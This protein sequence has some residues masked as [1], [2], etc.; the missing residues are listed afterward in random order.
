MNSFGIKR[1]KGHVRRVP[2]TMNKLEAAWATELDSQKNQGVIL[3]YWFEG[4]KLRLAKNTFLTPDFV[5]QLP[6]GQLE[7]HEVKGFMQDDA[8]VKLKVAASLYPFTFKLIKR[9]KKQWS[10]EPVGV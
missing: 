10:V 1:F 9:Q 6:D 5:V 3:A 7:V 8:A 2:G 4:I